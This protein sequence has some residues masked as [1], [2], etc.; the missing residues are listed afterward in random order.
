MDRRIIGKNALLDAGRR[1]AARGCGRGGPRA[2]VVAPR[3]NCC[4]GDHQLQLVANSRPAEAGCC[5]WVGGRVGGAVA[6]A[7]GMAPG[8]EPGDGEDYRLAKHPK[9]SVIGGG[10]SEKSI[11]HIIRRYPLY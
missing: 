9:E 7:G 11:G 6:M 5:S 2:G 10:G 8:N 3:G 4:V 1:H